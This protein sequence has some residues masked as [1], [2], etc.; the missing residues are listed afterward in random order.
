MILSFL[1]Y[2]FK[3]YNFKLRFTCTET[4]L[5]SFEI[6]LYKFFRINSDNYRNKSSKN[7]ESVSQIL[8]YKSDLICLNISL[9][10]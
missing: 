7:T 6:S 1:S 3:V 2:L 9:I 10:I 8:S 4:N 5:N